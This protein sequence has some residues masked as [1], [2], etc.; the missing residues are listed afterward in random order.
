M[1]GISIGVVRR[2]N[3]AD[4]ATIWSL[5][6]AAEQTDGAAP[7]PEQVLLHLKAHRSDTD[8]WHFVARR[9]NVQGSVSG[10]GADR[11]RLPGQ[12]EP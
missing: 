1:T 9:L 8:A 7:L 10:L 6:Q 12:V 11:L 5:A 2:P 3:E 4:V